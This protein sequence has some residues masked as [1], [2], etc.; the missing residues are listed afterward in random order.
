LR[1]HLTGDADFANN[2]RALRK[3]GC[4]IIVDDIIYF[5]EPVFQDGIIAQAVNDVTAS[6]A[7]YFSSAGNEGNKN[8]GT[9]GVWEGN[10]VDGGAAPF[11][12]SG[13]VHKFS[14]DCRV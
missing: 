11:G 14:K 4:D 12:L 10:F 2:I 3:A 6:G 9:S 5:R 13:R 1:P 8:D 7:L